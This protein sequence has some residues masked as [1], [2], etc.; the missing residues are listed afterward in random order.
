MR[1]HDD[2]DELMQHVDDLLDEEYTPDRSEPFWDADFG[3]E[4]E[5]V[6]RGAAGGEPVWR[7]AAN[8]Y[9]AAF[10]QAPE[11]PDYDEEAAAI[12]YDPQTNRGSSIPAYNADYANRAVSRARKKKSPPPARHSSAADGD[13][14]RQIPASE[15]QKLWKMQPE[16]TTGY[17]AYNPQTPAYEPDY[18]AEY[19]EP[20]PSRRKSRQEAKQ[21]VS[22]RPKRKKKHRILKLILIL[23]VLLAVFGVK[24]YNWSSIVCQ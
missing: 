9:G 3:S 16:R 4:Y 21:P 11:E 17:A 1:D 10:E 8:G 22:H 20:A 14:T 15:V 19:D 6:P 2:Y 13:E 24:Y 12:R 7:N 23:L 18:D 5:D